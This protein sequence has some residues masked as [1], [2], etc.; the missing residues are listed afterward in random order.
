MIRDTFTRFCRRSRVNARRTLQLEE[1]RLRGEVPVLRNTGAVHCT[2]V[3]AINIS[4]NGSGKSAAHDMTAPAADA[5]ME[6]AEGDIGEA[7]A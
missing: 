3:I 2:A 4:G 6:E 5:R 1:G 7:C